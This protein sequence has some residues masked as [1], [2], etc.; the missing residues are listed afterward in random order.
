M[1]L[2]E[3]AEAVDLA[4]RAGIDRKVTKIASHVLTE[5]LRGLVSSSAIFF[6]GLHDHPIKVVSKL[7]CEV[8]RVRVSLFGD[9]FL[10]V[11]TEGRKSGGGSGRL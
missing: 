2:H 1:P 7:A 9:L 11:F 8:L 6:N 10:F 5:F 3:L 4:G